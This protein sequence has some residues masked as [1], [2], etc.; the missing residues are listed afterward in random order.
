MTHTT[1]NGFSEATASLNNM[2]R[3]LLLR[4]A[5]IAG[6]LGALLFVSVGL[7]VEI[8]HVAVSGILVLWAMA[9]AAAWVRFERQ[10]AVSDFEF[11]LQL[12]IDVAMLSALLFFTGGS[13]NPLTLLLLLPLTVA[14]AMLPGAYPWIVATVTVA[15]YAALLFM[16]VPLPAIEQP[17]GHELRVHVLGM[18]SGFVLIATLIATF[19]ANMGR[20]LRD[21][22]AVIADAREQAMRDEKIV[23]LGALAAG[24]AHELGTPLGTIAVLAKEMEHDL[25]GS[26]PE[27]ADRL[28]VMRDQVARC[29]S[30]LAT[31]SLSAGQCQAGSGRAVPVDRYL[32]DMVRQWTTMRPTV[33]VAYESRGIAPAP[34]IVAEQTLAQA[35]TSIFNNA[36]D[37]SNEVEIVTDWNRTTLE[38]EVKDRGRGFTPDARSAAGRMGFTTKP[39]EKGLGL[40]LYL[41]YSV[42]NRLG[43]EVSLYNREGGGGCTRVVLPLAA[44]LGSAAETDHH[45][46]S[47]HDRSAAS[48]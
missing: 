22:E 7:Q 33:R 32:D 31:L 16:Y 34:V 44:L 46:Y 38:V 43:G 2:R 6:W 35:L 11:F 45:G 26:Q 41:T 24:A 13:T 23:A 17:A 29:K 9:A 39:P 8:A 36:A 1:M 15:C 25:A 14:A 42:I 5:A 4:A 12:M 27:L 10:G 19:V 40:G 20:T 47:A 18:W 21:R 28:R 37:A 30:V 48:G 3:L